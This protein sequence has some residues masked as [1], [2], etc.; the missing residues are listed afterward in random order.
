[1]FGLLL[2]VNRG[3]DTGWFHPLILGSG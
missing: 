2:A 1:M 3:N